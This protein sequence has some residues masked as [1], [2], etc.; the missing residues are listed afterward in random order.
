M[1]NIGWA[2]C[3]HDLLFGVKDDI[4][5]TF[6]GRLDAAKGRVRAREEVGVRGGWR[7]QN[8]LN[9]KASNPSEILGVRKGLIHKEPSAASGLPFISEPIWPADPAFVLVQT[10][11]VA[12]Y[13]IG[14]R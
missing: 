6:R 10:V 5:K 2:I 11:W 4:V 14:L 12:W 3:L 9:K 1:T 8:Y 13:V 7:G